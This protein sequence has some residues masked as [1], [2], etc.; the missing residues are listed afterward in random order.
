MNMYPGT[1]IVN[2]G[3]CVWTEYTNC[4]W[5][6]NWTLPRFLGFTSARPSSSELLLSNAGDRD[7]I[8][9]SDQLKAQIHKKL[10]S[11]F[12]IIIPVDDT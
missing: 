2:T 5:P 10:I 1:Y 9:N 8:V 12:E 4:D 11:V 6:P 3:T 7:V